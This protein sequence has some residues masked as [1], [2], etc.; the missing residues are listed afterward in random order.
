MDSNQKQSNTK[1]LQGSTNAS[2]SLGIGII[3]IVYFA[4]I[5]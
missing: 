3:C 1:R 2:V 5:L 4:L